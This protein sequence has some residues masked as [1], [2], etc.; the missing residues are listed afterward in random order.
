[1]ELEFLREVDPALQQL[2]LERASLQDRMLEATTRTTPGWDA[3][4]EGLRRQLGQLD[5]R[6][7]AEHGPELIAAL[8][9]LYFVVL[10]IQMLLFDPT[11]PVPDLDREAMLKGPRSTVFAELRELSSVAR[12]AA[13]QIQTFAFVPQGG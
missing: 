8:N 2:Y 1:M 5:D 10:E 12:Q 11:D 3:E 7:T 6:V 4:Y 13:S 9:D